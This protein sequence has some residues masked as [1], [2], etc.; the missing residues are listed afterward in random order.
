[1]H[2]VIFHPGFKVALI[3]KFTEIIFA[4][5][6]QMQLPVK[7]RRPL[8]RDSRYAFKRDTQTNVLGF[9]FM[10]NETQRYYDLNSEQI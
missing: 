8:K 4:P 1:M 5:Y 9:L 2:S 3:R 6:T 10:G 7:F